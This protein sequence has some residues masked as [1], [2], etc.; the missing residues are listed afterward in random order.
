MR[1]SRRAGLAAPPTSTGLCERL[2]LEPQGAVQRRPVHRLRMVGPGLYPVSDAGIAWRI[3]AHPLGQA[4]HLAPDCIAGST[5][6]VLPPDF[7]RIRHYGLLSPAV[8]TARRAA[9]RAIG[10]SYLIEWASHT[11]TPTVE[12]MG[13]NHRCRN[14]AVAEQLLNRANIV[15]SLQQMRSKGMA[16]YVWGTRFNNTRSLGR[17]RHRFLHRNLAQVMPVKFASPRVYRSTAARENPLPAPRLGSIW[18]LCVQRTRQP[19][20]AETHG[21]VTLVQCPRPGHL[22]LKRQDQILRQDRNPVLGTFAVPNQDLPPLELD[23]FDAQPQSLS[24]S[25]ASAVQHG[26]HESDRA[27]HLVKQQAHLGGSQYHR[28]PAWAPGGNDVVQP[29]QLNLQDHFVQKQDGRLRLPLGR[30][31]NMPVHCQVS[32]EGCHFCR[33]EFAGMALAVKDDEAPDPVRVGFLG[34][35]R[36]VSNPNLLPQS[37][38]QTRLSGGRAGRRW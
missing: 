15:A 3:A 14:I 23:V 6:P 22:L 12:D 13:V 19:D 34:A 17:K 24:Q 10:C 16:Q 8:K 21:Q 27:A 35:D 18:I 26:C 28:Q 4:Q 38:H 9:A 7:N 25:H 31:G 5:A 32:Q 1:C 36:V 37:I 33:T 11:A 2:G 20:V 29:R 30:R